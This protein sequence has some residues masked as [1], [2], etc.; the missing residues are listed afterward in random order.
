MAG[1]FPITKKWE[2][3]DTVRPIQ[4]H[5]ETNFNPVRNGVDE[6]GDSE[7]EAEARGSDPWEEV[8]KK[9]ENLETRLTEYFENE[10]EQGREPPP[11]V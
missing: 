1:Y 2:R 3:V 4:R 7:V 9:M 11:I 8:S 6:H 5:T 10:H